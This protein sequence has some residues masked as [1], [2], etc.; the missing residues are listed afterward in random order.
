M[1]NP[2]QFIQEARAEGAKVTW[3]NRKETLLTTA[4]VLAMVVVAS[5]FFLL[6]DWSMRFVVTF[7]LTLGH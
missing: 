6:V 2:F 5:A 3:P 4:L 1:L 7:L